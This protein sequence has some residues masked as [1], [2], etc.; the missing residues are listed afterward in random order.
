MR[1][2]QHCPTSQSSS[3]PSKLR[4]HDHVHLRSAGLVLYLI[5]LLLEKA[6]VGWITILV[7]LL[8]AVLLMLYKIWLDHWERYAAAN[9]APDA[10]KKTI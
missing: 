3:K 7:E 1:S 4:V 10:N 2:Q 8:V 9:Q 6:L 5:Y